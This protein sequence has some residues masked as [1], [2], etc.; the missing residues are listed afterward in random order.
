M[1]KTRTFLEQVE[2]LT[3][4]WA[5]CGEMNKS[6]QNRLIDILV[7]IPGFLQD[8]AALEH[9]PSRRFQ[10]D[11]IQR[12]E[13]QIAKAHNWRWQWEEMNPQV[14]WEVEP[15][16]LP[17]DQVLTQHRPIRK[18]LQFSSFSKA[19]E[20]CLYNAVLLF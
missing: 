17:A 18:V 15:E 16:L 10:L 1:T 6:A 19:T 3:E 11:L 12:I 9:A 2:W 13:Y 7:H 8:Q 20:L 4:P 14:V 5:A